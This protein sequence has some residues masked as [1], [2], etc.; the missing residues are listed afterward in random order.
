MY[1]RYTVRRYFNHQKQLSIWKAI[2]PPL[3]DSHGLDVVYP[4]PTKMLNTISLN[5][6]TLFELPG[7]CVKRIGTAPHFRQ[8]FRNIFLHSAESGAFSKVLVDTA[9]ILW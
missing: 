1:Y 7:N 5:G 9:R 6:R 2:Q 4:E 3:T 8:S